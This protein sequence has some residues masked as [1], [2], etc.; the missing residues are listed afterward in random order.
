M[1][2]KYKNQKVKK[3]RVYRKIKMQMRRNTLFTNFINLV[4]NLNFK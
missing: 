3:N 1:F 2:N 4:K